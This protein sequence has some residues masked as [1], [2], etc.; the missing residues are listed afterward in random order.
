MLCWSTWLCAGPLFDPTLRLNPINTLN[1]ASISQM[2][3]FSSLGVPMDPSTTASLLDTVNNA[4]TIASLDLSNSSLGDAGASVVAEKLKINFNITTTNLS[5]N[6]IGDAGAT[7]LAHLVRNN[8]HLQNLSLNTNLITDE[9]A[10]ALAAAAT[11]TRTLKTLDL[12]GNKFGP[13]GITALIQA[14]HLNPGV[15]ITFDGDPSITNSIQPKIESFSIDSLP[16]L[17]TMK[18]WDLSNLKVGPPLVK[19]LEPFLRHSNVLTNLQIAGNKLGDDAAADLLRILTH[20]ATIETLDLS[21]NN[22][23]AMSANAISQYI[24]NN[25]KLQNLNLSNNTLGPAAIESIARAMA[26]HPN[27]KILTLNKTGCEDTGAMALGNAL[28]LNITLQTLSLRSNQITPMGASALAAGSAKNMTLTTLELN[29]NFLD[30]TT[31]QTFAQTALAPNLS[32]PKFAD[33]TPNLATLSRANE[34]LFVTPAPPKFIDTSVTSIKFVAPDVPVTSFT[35]TAI[36]TGK[37][38]DGDTDT[39]KFIVAPSTTIL[40]S[41]NTVQTTFTSGQQTF[42]PAANTST[43]LGDAGS[44]VGFF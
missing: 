34:S 32:T 7:A 33:S 29:D 24:T 23:T 6:Q 15:K 22:L 44:T 8:V 38:M 26:Q 39:A 28:A 43:G 18:T 10:S 4:P 31:V 35:T 2:S 37:F 19:I 1:T 30:I 16:N 27:L 25:P 36:S 41:T 12:T 40:P 17:P 11:E 5:K 3:S 14:R 21:D 13:M 42:I 20:H 9:G